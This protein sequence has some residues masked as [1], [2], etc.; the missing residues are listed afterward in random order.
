MV[1]LLYLKCFYKG[2]QANDFTMVNILPTPS[3]T[4]QLQT[5]KFCFNFIA[6]WPSLGRFGV[7][8]LDAVSRNPG[9]S[10]K[11]IWNST[12]AA[13][14]FSWEP[15][16]RKSAWRMQPCGDHNDFPV[17]K[18]LPFWCEKAL[19]ATNGISD[20]GEVGWEL[21]QILLSQL[22][23]SPFLK[24][25]AALRKKNCP[26]KD[27]KLSNRGIAVVCRANVTGILNNNFKT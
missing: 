25:P 19:N 26:H 13:W 3:Q 10:C 12:L 15:E 22:L 27:R 21:M 14:C 2:K 23:V 17:Q 6:S 18:H 1:I 20:V 9:L 4:G 16:R 11:A 24:A 5:Q 8:C 7:S